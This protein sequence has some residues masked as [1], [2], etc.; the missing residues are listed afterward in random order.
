[1]DTKETLCII[2][3]SVIAIFMISIP[4]LFVFSII[5]KWYGFIIMI[6]CLATL[7]DIIIITGILYEEVN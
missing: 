3:C 7:F 2:G 6:L 1:M 4:I 5:Y